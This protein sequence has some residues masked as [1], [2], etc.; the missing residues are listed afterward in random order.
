MAHKYLSKRKTQ[1]FRKQ[2]INEQRKASIKSGE[3][4]R[5]TKMKAK[6]REQIQGQEDCENRSEEPI[7][8]KEDAKGDGA[9][10]VLGCVLG[11]VDAKEPPA[12]YTDAG[13]CPQQPDAEYTDAGKD[14][15]PYKIDVRLRPMK[16]RK[17]LEEEKK[18]EW[19]CLSTRVETTSFRPISTTS[20]TSSTNSISSPEPVDDNPPSETML[21]FCAISD[22]PDTVLDLSF[23]EDEKE[24]TAESRLSFFLPSKEIFFPIEELIYMIRLGFSGKDMERLCKMPLFDKAG[25]VSRILGFT[26]CAIFSN[27]DKAH[28]ILFGSA[29]KDLNL[30][31][32]TNLVFANLVGQPNEGKPLLDVIRNDLCSKE[33]IM[34]EV[35]RLSVISRVYILHQL[36]FESREKTFVEAY[37]GGNL[38]NIM[39]EA[40]EVLGKT[41]QGISQ[42][43]IDFIKLLVV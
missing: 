9:L 30:V 25:F 40:S 23:L 7:A 10:K 4:R 1:T 39:Q 33:L 16:V 38:F 5:V 2:N 11:C 41:S 21:R 15:E 32:R 28:T 18:E 24:E 37:T 13:E 42:D 34:R 3:A 26:S 36:L 35:C 31:R 27:V 43:S 8:Q 6:L 20:S 29:N 14:V 22:N 17:M 12:E 19:P